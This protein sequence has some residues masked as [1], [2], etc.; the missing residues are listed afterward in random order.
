MKT[1]M[2]GILWI[3]CFILLLPLFLLYVLR[4]VQF[5]TVAQLLSLVPGTLGVVMRRVWYA[6]TLERCG[7]NLTVDFLGILRSP[8]SHVGDNVYVGVNS[9]V[10]LVSIGSDVMISG[11]VLVL[12][13]GAQHG[14]E[15]LDVPM[16]LQ[17]GTVKHITIGDDV[18]VGAGARILADVAP[19]SVVGTGS[20]VTK[21]FAQYDIIAGIPAKKIKSRR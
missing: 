11:H 9:L 3:V 12:S 16:R 21:S 1:I 20:V 17:A 6:C 15:Q 2:L 10:G 8:R 4:L 14:I 7:K 13:G 18:W 19:H 5:F